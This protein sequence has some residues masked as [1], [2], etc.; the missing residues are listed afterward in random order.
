[1]KKLIYLCL[2]ASL[3]MSSESI[4]SEL[5]QE[6]L[7]LKEKSV[8]KSSDL[9][10]NSWINPLTLSIGANKNQITSKLGSQRSVSAR[11]SFNQDIYR[12]GG[13]FHAIDYAK[14]TRLLGLSQ[15]KSE[16]NANILTA[17]SMLVKILKNDKLQEQQKF[18][19]KNSNLDIKRKKEQYSA[20]LVDIS[21]LNNAI[22]QKMAQENGLIKL[23]EAK[24]S[25][26]LEFEK[27]SD[28]DYKTI[29]MP[30]IKIPSQSNY[31]SQNLALLVQ[32]NNINT[33]EYYS[34]MVKA[35]YLPRVSVNANYTLSDIKNRQVDMSDNHYGYGISASMPFDIKKSDDVEKS[36]LDYMI[37]KNELSILEN[38]QKKEYKKILVDLKKIDKKIQLAQDNI[39]IY[40]SLLG[41]TK[42]LVD[43]GIQ[44]EDDLTIMQNSKEIRVLEEKLYLLEKEE[45]KLEFYK[46]LAVSF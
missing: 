20:G 10:E 40:D 16:K 36:R 29:K 42:D 11:L 2:V 38:T 22:L 18:S 14:A 8:E 9:L 33:K 44:I 21:F 28:K 23:E 41:Q 4:L 5:K 3:G 17:Y 15:I 43:A 31:I 39:K 46:K 32:K 6:N 13:I 26:I 19:I 24:Q 35:K 37:A 27:L 45:K 7:K 30:T 1:M 25:L 12:S 34:K